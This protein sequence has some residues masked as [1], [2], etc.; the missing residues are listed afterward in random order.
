MKIAL[1][2]TLLFFSIISASVAQPL[3]DSL[4]MWYRADSGVISVAGKVNTWQDLSGHGSDLLQFTSDNQ[5]SYIDSLQSLNNLPVVR[6][7]GVD[8]YFKTAPFASNLFSPL[9]VYLVWANPSKD[10]YILFDGIDE[11]YRIVMYDNYHQITIYENAALSYSQNPPF[12]IISTAIFNQANSKLYENGLLM[13]S[14]SLS[15][16]SL[17]GLTVGARCN[18]AYTFLGD[19]AEILVYNTVHTDSERSQVLSYLQNKYAPPV[20]LGPDLSIPY[21]FCNT[22]LHAGSRFKDYLWSTGDTAN[23][24]IVNASGTYSV[25]VTDIFGFT[26]KDTIVVN[27]PT[28]NIP[29]TTI[30]QFTTAHLDSHLGADYTFL[31]SDSTT[32]ADFYT[33]SAGAH[34]INISDT[35]GCQFRDTMIVSIDSF[36]STAS[37]GPDRSACRGEILALAQ[38]QAEATTYL[39]STGSGSGQILINATPGTT[40]VYSLTVGNALGCQAKDTINIFIRGDVPTPAFTADSVCPGLPTSFTDQS[41]ALPP[42]V[43][44]A[45]QWSFGDGDSSTLHHPTHVFPQSGIYNVSLKVTTDSGCYK[46]FTKQV[47]VWA[48]PA[49]MFSPSH[50]CSGT[51][52]PFSDHSTNA[53]GSND[54]WHWDFGVPGNTDTSNAQN[55]SFTYAI[56]GVYP[57]LLQVTSV[58]GCSDTLQRSIEIKESPQAGFSVSQSCQ[59]QI[60]YF[61]DTTH[62][63]VPTMILS[64]K[65]DFDDDSISYNAS[66]TYRYTTVGDYNVSLLISSING[67]TSSATQVVSVHPL[68][69]AQIGLT[70]LCVGVPGQLLDQSTISG[71][72]INSWFWTFSDGSTSN[73][74]NPWFTPD[75]SGD[76]NT[77]LMVSTANGCG[78][79]THRILSA[80]PLPHAAFSFSPEFGTAPLTVDFT[81]LSTG[82]A[83][84]LWTF[85]DGGTSTDENPQYI[86]NTQGVYPV[87][88]TAYNSFGCPDSTSQLMYVLLLKTD[89]AVSKAKAVLDGDLLHMSARLTN[90]GT[91]NISNLLLKARFNGSNTMAES[92]TGILEPGQSIDYTFSSLLEIPT[93]SQLDYACVEAEVTGYTDDKPE[94]N[95][96]CAVLT[97]T[98]TV[99]NPYPNP[100]SGEIAID[101]ILPF[102]DA[103]NVKIYNESGK[104]M[105]DLF[106]GTG[107]DGYTR[108]TYDASV[109]QAG[110]YAVHVVFRDKKEVRKFVR[111]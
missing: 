81:N 103:L 30:C 107:N 61:V 11:A 50:G 76:H 53:L 91:R 105:A 85:G 1:L 15:I 88:L 108:F 51:V 22:T 38:G 42:A 48:K 2:Y 82:D 54:H 12:T 83:S 10:F 6:F 55:P 7:D 64:H 111:R 45:W 40:Q 104:K 95:S 34:W 87:T 70:S 62:T 46:S 33:D 57:V 20:N 13:A 72:A 68:P 97:E 94:N 21:G 74:Q 23:S 89:I 49:V 60:V 65:W 110:T 79:T 63:S 31:W 102:S 69:V 35:L 17:A 66:P 80:Y 26:S 43:P 77:T 39:W 37:L 36:P 59:N 32:N 16:S 24:I 75:S 4:R 56:P 98:F 99:S 52:I 58:A 84:W 96:D 100:S 19:M 47:V 14:G 86:F 73:Q 3:Q 29:D 28:L 109:L 67:C 25:T 93:N 27:K 9:T 41:T 71:D 106:D 8:D 18:G 101:V 90:N 92:W 5:A 78:D 44:N